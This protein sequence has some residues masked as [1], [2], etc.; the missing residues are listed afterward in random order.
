MS[1]QQLLLA[2]YRAP[3]DTLVMTALVRDIARAHPNKFQIDVDTSAM[4]FWR[5]NPYITHTPGV[6]R[7]KVIK[8]EYGLGIRDQN[9]ESVHFLSYFHR[10]FERRTG[11][12][13]PVTEPFP[14]LHLSVEERTVPLVSGRYWV[15]LSGGKSDFT[16]KVWH[17]DNF[18]GVVDRLRGLGLGVVQIGSNDAGHWHP[19][20]TG[21]LDLV[22]QTNLR[23]MIRVLQHSEGVICGVTCAMHM[24]AALQK[25]CV[26]LGGGREAWWWEAYVKENK[27]LVCPERLKVPH[28]YLHTIGLLDCCKLHGCWK[29]K[30]VPLKNDKSLCYHPV[31]R[32]GQ[33]V[34]LCLDMITVDHVMEAVM[35]NYTDKSLPPIN[36]GQIQLPEPAPVPTLATPPLP[37]NRRSLL[38]LFDDPPAEAPAAPPKMLVVGTPGQGQLVKAAVPVAALQLNPQAKM[39]TRGRIPLAVARAPGGI[40]GVIPGNEA[41]D[42]V[43][44][45]GKFTIFVLLYGPETFYELHSRC[46]NSII[47]T[48][49]RDRFDLRVGSNA[50]NPKSL[51]LVRTLCDNGTITKHYEH[52]ENLFKYPVMREMF[53]DPTCP[54]TT[55]WV[56]WFD[57]DSIADRTPAWGT[58]LA[59]QIVQYHR[60]NNAHMFGAPFISTADASQRRW[61]ESR[62]WYRGKPWRL[63]NGKT[64]PGGNRIHFCTG[65]FWAITH[66]AMVKCDIPDIEI[67]HN[68]GDITIGEQLYQGG[69][70]M[71][72][73]NAQKQ[74]IYT[75]SVPRRGVTLPMPGQP[76][77]QAPRVIQV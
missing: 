29:N 49:P 59:Q 56:L 34:P 53:Y 1:K 58:L 62:S 3:G 66:E 51:Q 54:I 14:D 10:D 44:V 28:A 77:H 50:L 68:G 72:A 42:H 74:F 47:S 38:S 69:F 57:D 36:A 46:L 67:G 20:L 19:E 76:G 4:D 6:K 18:Q 27:G 60:R 55:K 48:L 73:W 30:V 65:G 24:A 37:P 31:I 43:D 17:K 33:P 22:G 7:G 41:F 61:Y 5:N 35:K 52:K 26:V 12:H 39:E 64:G 63:H 40:A 21:T 25:P 75:S 70:A 9:F 11:F 2:H 23:D 45:G 13:V 15:M 32:P 71:K 16:A 8:L